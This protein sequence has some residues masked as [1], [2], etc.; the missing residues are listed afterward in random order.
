MSTVEAYDPATD[1]WTRKAS[2]P[3]AKQ[4]LSSSVV[5]G[6]I[7]AIGGCG[8]PYSSNPYA[9]VHSY[10]PAT[11]SWTKMADMLP[12]A[13]KFHATC[14]VDGKIYAIGGSS[15]TAFNSSITMVEEYDIGLSVSSPDLNG[16]GIVDA[17]DMFIM[18]DNWLSEDPLC[19]IA[20]PL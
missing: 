1:V 12:T 20:P 8:D 4:F 16:D 6:K 3:T 9:T 14:A 18:V 15:V 2:M 10:D 13:R 5:N 11:D 19:D 7:Y 17:K